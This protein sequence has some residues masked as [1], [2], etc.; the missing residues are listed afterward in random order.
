M[1]NFEPHIPNKFIYHVSLKKTRESILKNGLI[2]MP[3][4]NSE[5]ARTSSLRYPDAIFV[6]N[7]MT[8]PGG[9]ILPM[10]CGKI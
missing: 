6:N 2:P 8:I 3:Y 10:E 4:D 9:F 1:R 7:Q 5:W